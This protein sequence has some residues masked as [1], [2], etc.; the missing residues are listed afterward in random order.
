M[1]QRILFSLLNR[2][3]TFNSSYLIQQNCRNNNFKYINQ[4][5]F[6]ISTK[7]NMVASKKDSQEAM[8]IAKAAAVERKARINDKNNN[9]LTLQH[10]DLVLTMWFG[11]E[12]TTEHK[13]K[14]WFKPDEDLDVELR[15]RFA[16]HVAA[17]LPMPKE[18]GNGE[19]K[20]GNGEGK[21][22]G[23]EG[24]GAKATWQ[25][26]APEAL[27]RLVAYD[28]FTRNVYRGQK[29]AFG[30][31]EDARVISKF[32]L[33]DEE[34]MKSFGP[35][36][37]SMI[38]MPLMHSE[39]MDDQKQCVENFQKLFD[40]TQDEEAKKLFAMNLKFAKL[41]MEEIEKFGRFPMR[42][43]ALGRESTEEEKKFI[44]EKEKQHG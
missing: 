37:V 13:A 24:E 2:T 43:K 35:F 44:E 4:R 30:R 42:N 11:G 17:P 12:Q 39:N 7:F 28:Q 9:K 26:N 16:L 25:K 15:R 21:E 10:W 36:Q 41:H 32:L 3:K 29:E 27:A 18:E 40:E 14:L 20:E 31:D 38:N 22:E 8:D 34:K 23:K 5:Y 6:F 19:G 1:H 33:A